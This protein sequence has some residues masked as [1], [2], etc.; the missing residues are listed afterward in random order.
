M[1][2]LNS[3]TMA[4][5]PLNCRIWFKQTTSRSVCRHRFHKALH[6]VLHPPLVLQAKARFPGSVSA[7]LQAVN[8]R[9]Q[10]RGSMKGL[11]LTAISNSFFYLS[12][13]VLGG[14]STL[15]GLGS[16]FESVTPRVK[17]YQRQITDK[18]LAM[19]FHGLCKGVRLQVLVSFTPRDETMLQPRPTF[20]HLLGHQPGSKI[21]MRTHTPT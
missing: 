2:A 7:Q 4:E 5:D 12:S 19:R 17:Q 18:I 9:L 14:R 8:Q 1:V 6:H 15:E 20:P 16:N 13:Y 3:R 10:D 11:S 21:V